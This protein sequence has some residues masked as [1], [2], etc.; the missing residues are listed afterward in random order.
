MKLLI[1]SL[2]TLLAFAPLTGYAAPNY[3]SS[4]FNGGSGA[5]SSGGS[6]GTPGGSNGQIQYNNNGSFGG[7]TLTTTGTTGAA[8]MTSGTLNIPQYSSST[9]Q[10]A[11]AA[12][13]QLSFGGL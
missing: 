12:E 5:T 1:C 6:G 3:G 8:T 11:A 9:F 10:A 13:M 7:V 4:V 2:F